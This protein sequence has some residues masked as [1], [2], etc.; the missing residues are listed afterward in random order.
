MDRVLQ[1]HVNTTAKNYKKDLDNA[2]REK[3][4][5]EQNKKKAEAK[6]KALKKKERQQAQEEEAKK[7]EA[8][9]RAKRV[10]AELSAELKRRAENKVKWAET[11]KRTRKPKLSKDVRQEQMSPDLSR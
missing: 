5:E 10:T 4:L 7:R 11:K 3:R 2:Q 9:E 8:A 1:A 6:A